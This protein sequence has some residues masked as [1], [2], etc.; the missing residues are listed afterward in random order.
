MQTHMVPFIGVSYHD[1][2]VG[3]G[4]TI[5]CISQLP[6]IVTIADNT[7]HSFGGKHRLETPPSL[8]PFRLTLHGHVPSFS[9]LS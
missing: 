9:Q 1:A 5:H 4:K 3:F 7:P 2:L 6:H 8:H